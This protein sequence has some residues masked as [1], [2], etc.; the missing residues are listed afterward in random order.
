MLKR[1]AKIST[2]GIG[3]GSTLYVYSRERRT[4]GSFS[5][6]S[7]VDRKPLCCDTAAVFKIF[8]RSYCYTVWS[9][10]GVILSSVRPSVCLY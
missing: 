1:T 3:I 4:I 10:I 5:A 8:S 2:S 6:T 7:I 9:A